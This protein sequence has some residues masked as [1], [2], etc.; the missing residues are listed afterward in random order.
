MQDD[1]EDLIA[2]VS[3][4]ADL[5]PAFARRLV[6]DVLAQFDETLEDFVQRRHAELVRQGLKNQAVFERLQSEI[7]GRR[8][9]SHKLSLR[10]IRRIIYG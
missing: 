7:P 8:Y 10:Q 5:P 9:L 4:S 2:H 1:I 3:R 6:G